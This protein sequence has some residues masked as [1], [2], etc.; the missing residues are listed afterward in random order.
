MMS[1]W[2]GYWT[3]AH[4]AVENE[5]AELLARLLSQG[6]D[7]NETCQGMTLLTHAIDAEGDGA[8][9]SGHP[10]TVH[11]TAVLLAFG[12]DP[13]LVDPAGRTPTEV[14]RRHGHTMAEGLLQAHLAK[15][16]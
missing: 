7:P 9:Q 14:A 2:E 3:A 8:V 13:K 11:T 1:E 15:A 5:D 12:A 16:R 4:A 10:L 6:A